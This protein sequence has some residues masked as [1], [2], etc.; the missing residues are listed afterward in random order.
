MAYGIWNQYPWGSG[1][2]QQSIT[3]NYDNSTAWDYNQT[4]YVFHTGGSAYT[5]NWPPAQ[6]AM[7]K[8]ESAMEWLR[9]RV[10][11]VTDLAYAGV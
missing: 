6:Q 1:A 8:V 10:T 7:E 11:E 5:Y 9:R 3:I 4:G 2:T